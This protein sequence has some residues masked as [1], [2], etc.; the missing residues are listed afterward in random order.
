MARKPSK[1]PVLQPQLAPKQR[2]AVAAIAWLLPIRH[3][4]IWYST[5]KSVTC[6]CS[7]CF[8]YDPMRQAASRVL[9]S[10]AVAVGAV[11]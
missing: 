4:L 7:S 5:G 10:A 2:S 1:S 6:I 11:L 9:P 3:A 8:R